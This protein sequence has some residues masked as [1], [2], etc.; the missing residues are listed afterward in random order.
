E[1]ASIHTGILSFE[2]LDQSSGSR[3]HK[4]S[5]EELVGVGI[6]P[7]H[8]DSFLR[9]THKI[10]PISQPRDP[11]ELSIFTIRGLMGT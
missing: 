9:Q 3:Q 6:L 10:D 5:S 1:K 11:P 8:P 2:K 7:G 4:M